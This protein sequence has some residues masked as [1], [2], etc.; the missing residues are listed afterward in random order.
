M[1][2]IEYGFNYWEL[3]WWWKQQITVKRNHIVGKHQKIGGHTVCQN[4][5]IRKL[6]PLT[7]SI[8][9]RRWYLPNYVSQSPR[10][11]VWNRG[12]APKYLTA[13]SLFVVPLDWKCKGIC[14]FVDSDIDYFN[15]LS[16]SIYSLTCAKSPKMSKNWKELSSNS[17]SSKG[18][19]HRN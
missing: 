18:F 4:M 19:R 6:A 12:N 8:S 1:T 14:A 5:D 7:P 3:W 2:G 13:W 9:I 17:Q 15:K 10:L 16:L 11:A